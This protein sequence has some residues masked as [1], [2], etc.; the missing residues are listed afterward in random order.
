MP[1]L[2]ERRLVRPSETVGLQLT[3]PSWSAVRHAHSQLVE[4]IEAS[5]YPS[6]FAPSRPT[7]SGRVGKTPLGSS[8]RTRSSFDL[9]TGGI[10]LSGSGPRDIERSSRATTSKEHENA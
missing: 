9:P 10:A 8:S 2:N 6:S 4:A 7:C 5:A 3:A 1:L